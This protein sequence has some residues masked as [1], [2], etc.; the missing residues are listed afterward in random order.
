MD[1]RKQVLGIAIG[2][3]ITISFITPVYSYYSSYSNIC[4]LTVS[5]L[6]QIIANVIDA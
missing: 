3:F 4:D 2:F 5:D 6:E 1:I